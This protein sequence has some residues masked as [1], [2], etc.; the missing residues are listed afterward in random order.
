MYFLSSQLFLICGCSL[1][2]SV[3]IVVDDSI[4]LSCVCVCYT[5]LCVCVWTNRRQSCHKTPSRSLDRPPAVPGCRS[6][7]LRAEQRRGV[8]LIRVDQ[9]ESHMKTTEPHREG[10]ERVC[11]QAVPA[12]RRGARRW[13]D[14]AGRSVCECELLW[15]SA[16][17]PH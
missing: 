2:F 3:L 11:A 5:V 10:G 16:A 7:S 9:S 17:E 13:A 1:M 6:D 4:L 15:D 14:G 8:R 12:H